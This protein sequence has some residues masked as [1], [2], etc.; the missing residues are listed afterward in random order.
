MHN[1]LDTRHFLT[2]V[3]SLVL[4]VGCRGNQFDVG[5]LGTVQGQV[6]YEST[7]VPEGTVQFSHVQKG[8]AG[9][10]RID[11]EGHYVIK[12]ELGGL[13]IGEYKVSVMPPFVVIDGGPATPASEG[14]KEM[15]TIPI[16]YRSTETSG[17]TVEIHKGENTYDIKMNA[18]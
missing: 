14:P 4:A 12:S 1:S 6:T 17:L 9:I 7:A 11:K 16:K 10:G 3:A 2:M 18:K 13:P 15:R 8:Y 5:P